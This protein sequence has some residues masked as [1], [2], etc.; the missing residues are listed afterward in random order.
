[1]KRAK[2]IFQQFLF[3]TILVVTIGCSAPTVHVNKLYITEQESKKLS[4]ALNKLGFNVEFNEL[5]YPESVHSTSLLYSPFVEDNTAVDKIENV[6]KSFGY[7]LSSVNALVAS[8]HWYTKNTIGLFVV[9]AG[10]IP[11]SGQ[12]SE[13]IAFSYHSSECETSSELHLKGGGEFIYEGTD[14]IKVSGEW[15]ITDYPYLL[16]TNNEPYLNF[17]FEIKKSTRVDVIGE[18]EVINLQ[19]INRSRLISNCTLTYGVRS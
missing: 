19:P 14:E 4:V 5:R 15:T 6:L 3:I 10:V 2:L 8:N 18:V 17:Y 9:P 12:R 11:N 7:N 16:L 1:M 13:D